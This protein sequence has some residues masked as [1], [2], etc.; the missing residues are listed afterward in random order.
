MIDIRTAKALSM[1]PFG[2]LVT[3]SRQ[4]PPTP[5]GNSTGA[6]S[7][8][9]RSSHSPS[10]SMLSVGWSASAVHQI[11]RK[12]VWY[13]SG[14]CLFRWCVTTLHVGVKGRYRRVSRRPSA[15][16][17]AIADHR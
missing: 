15:D 4:W 11:C 5:T 10:A 14:T 8:S 3:K 7:N 17:V 6:P 16:P 1:A 2:R 12:P 9:D 13:S